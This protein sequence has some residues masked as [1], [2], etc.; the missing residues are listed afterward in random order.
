V[1]LREVV[2]DVQLPPAFSLDSISLISRSK[3][4][5]RFSFILDPPC[6]VETDTGGDS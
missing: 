1:Q 4:S 3:D 6:R 5:G 2:E